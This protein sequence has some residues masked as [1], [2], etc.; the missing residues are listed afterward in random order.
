MSQEPRNTDY[1]R[2]CVDYIQDDTLEAILE[3]QQH[4]QHA[5]HRRVRRRLDN[6][7]LDSQ[8][9]EQVSIIVTEEQAI[10]FQE[11]LQRRRLDRG[12]SGCNSE[13]NSASSS[14]A[15]MS[16]DSSDARRRST[17]SPDPL[18]RGEPAARSSS[19]EID[20]SST[21][22]GVGHSLERQ[23][24]PLDINATT[25]APLVGSS[26]PWQIIGFEGQGPPDHRAPDDADPLTHTDFTDLLTEDDLADLGFYLGGGYPERC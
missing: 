6:L 5:T 4:L 9:R 17:P 2:P 23:G 3:C 8:T 13:E 10:A 12:R 1:S 18:S 7:D 15:E 16:Q 20:C 21:G 11:Y 25:E 19:Q 14:I 26:S 24:P 22:F